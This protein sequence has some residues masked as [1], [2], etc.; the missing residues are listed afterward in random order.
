MLRAA[1]LTVGVGLILVCFAVAQ[2]QVLLWEQ[3]IFYAPIRLS[4]LWTAIWGDLPDPLWLRHVSGIEAWLLDQPVN[5]VLGL[6]GGCLTWI[7]VD[8]FGLISSRL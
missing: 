6:A 1:T 4:A 2:N 8:G 7:G 5:K 3:D